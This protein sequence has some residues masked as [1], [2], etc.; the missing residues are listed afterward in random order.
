MLYTIAM[1][2]SL[3][4]SASETPDLPHQRFDSV[5]KDVVQTFPEDL[6]WFLMPSSDIEF[7]E[8]LESELTTV[9]TRQMDSLIK[10][11]LAGEEVLVH[12]EFQTA[13]S[14]HADM[15]RRTVGYL[16]RCYERYGLPICSH[17]IYLRP[18][19]GRNDP[20]R[21]VQ[22]IA[23][24]PIIVGYKVIRLIE[25]DGVAVLAAQP[26]GLM[27]FCPLMKPPKGM[28]ALAWLNQCVETTKSLALEA[29]T[30]TNLLLEMWVMAGLVHDADAIAHLFPEDLMQESSVYQDITQRARAEGIQ[31]ATKANTIENILLVLDTRFAAD[32]AVTL[33]TALEAIDDPQRL[34]AL[35]REAAEI[36]TLAAF[37]EKLA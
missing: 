11:R 7:L 18:E 24:Y 30:R 9:E 28:D 31:Q 35:L 5:A 32:T 4:Q 14:T 1:K 16:G 36:E 10:V 27:P 37:I 20:G 23:G 17:I 19:A 25:V 34:K 22:D 6:L 26:P 21:Y 12:C 13:D 2:N 15:T 8:H 29:S 33:Q 3:T